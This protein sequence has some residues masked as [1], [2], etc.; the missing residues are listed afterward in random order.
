M[1]ENQKHSQN[2]RID[3]LEAE[4]L[5]LCELYDVKS[6]EYA[7]L[8]LKAEERL[9]TNEE[10]NK[11]KDLEKEITELE[12]RRKEL[13]AHISNITNALDA[14]KSVSPKGLIQ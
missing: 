6:S 10:K 5:K 2:E 13:N 3:E 8:S 11:A 1:P 9:L 4:Y 12:R 7:D 14:F